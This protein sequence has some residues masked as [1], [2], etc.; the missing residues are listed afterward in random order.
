[1]HDHHPTTEDRRLNEAVTVYCQYWMREPAPPKTFAFLKR[2]FEKVG[3]RWVPNETS[4]YVTNGNVDSERY[5]FENMFSFATEEELAA[6]S[7]NHNVTDAQERETRSRIYR[8]I[9]KSDVFDHLMPAESRAYWRISERIPKLIACSALTAVMYLG[10]L[11]APSLLYQDLLPAQALSQTYQGPHDSQIRDKEFVRKLREIVIAPAA[12]SLPSFRLSS[13]EEFKSTYGAARDLVWSKRLELGKLSSKLTWTLSS[14]QQK[15]D[16]ATF[17]V[18]KE[19]L[20]NSPDKLADFL[21]KTLL[22]VTPWNNLAEVATQV[23]MVLCAFALLTLYFSRKRELLTV[24]TDCKVADRPFATVNCVNILGSAYRGRKRLHYLFAAIAAVVATCVHFYYIGGSF[25]KISQ[26]I[27]SLV[28]LRPYDYRLAADLT[29]IFIVQWLLQFLLVYMFVLVSWDVAVL[30]N[31]IRRLQRHLTRIGMFDHAPEA[32]SAELARTQTLV[33]AFLVIIFMV[34][35]SVA[36]YFKLVSAENA[37]LISSWASLD[38]APRVL[39]LFV[40]VLAVTGF[41]SFAAAP[42]YDSAKS[43]REELQ[44]RRR[45]RKLW[46]KEDDDYLGA[47]ITKFSQWVS[48]AKTIKELVHGAAT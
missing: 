24:V 12:S 22:V 46:T 26:P 45:V 43:I 20:I 17:A 38:D 11:A 18:F 32:R 28:G 2:I 29:P 31:C 23:I 42:M 5:H 41:L 44:K 21:S 10:V 40:P 35:L 19:I 47:A 37:G 15:V 4:A 8:S 16:A 3:W 33:R 36:G 39:Y 14:D 9:H 1:M 48:L 6:L 27:A 34:L 13:I 30:G 25:T 7:D